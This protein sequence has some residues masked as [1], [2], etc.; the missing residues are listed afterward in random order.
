MKIISSNVS[1]SKEDLDLVMVIP[2]I[3]KVLSLGTD[4]AGIAKYTL[5]VLPRSGT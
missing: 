1:G 3:E 5:Q 2:A 4:V